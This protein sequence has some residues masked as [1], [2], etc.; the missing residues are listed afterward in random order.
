MEHE[1]A[2]EDPDEMQDKALAKIL[3]GSKIMTEAA[4]LLIRS[5][6]LQ[7]DNIERGVIEPTLT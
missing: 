5:R 4:S 6:S 7:L 3:E 2:E 1:N